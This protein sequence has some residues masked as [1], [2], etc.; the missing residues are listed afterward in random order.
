MPEK[1]PQ[2]EV[3][4]SQIADRQFHVNDYEGQD[5]LSQGLAETHE[6]VSDTYQEGTFEDTNC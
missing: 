2:K 5:Q 3:N 6:Q 1:K 4:T